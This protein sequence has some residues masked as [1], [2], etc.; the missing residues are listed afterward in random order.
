MKFQLYGVHLFYSVDSEAESLLGEVVGGAVGVVV[1]L[2]LT[3]I[4]IVIVVAILL[5]SR[6]GH[7]STGIP[8]G[9]VILSSP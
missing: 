3:V 5:R 1:V 8:R 2:S 6:R 9:Y 4:V 7:Y